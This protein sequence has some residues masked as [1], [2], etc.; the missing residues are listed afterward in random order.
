MVVDSG[1]LEG[2]GC[3]VMYTIE[4]NLLHLNLGCHP[5]RDFAT[6]IGTIKSRLG[7]RIFLMV[8]IKN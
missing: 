3:W 8:F 2:G 5:N 1:V 7:W 4:N 6:T